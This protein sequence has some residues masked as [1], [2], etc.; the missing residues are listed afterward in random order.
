MAGSRVDQLL[1][2]RRGLLSWRRSRSLLLTKRR[3]CRPTAI[4]YRRQ[5]GRRGGKGCA[6]GGRKH[7]TSSQHGGLDGR[8]ANWHAKGCIPPACAQRPL[9][10]RLAA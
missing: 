3:C 5:C 8:L 4:R 9:G 2:H 1:M 6:A 7:V 10:C